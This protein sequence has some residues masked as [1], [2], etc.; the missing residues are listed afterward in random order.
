MSPFLATHAKGKVKLVTQ[1][2]KPIA[3]II[4]EL[5]LDIEVAAIGTSYPIDSSG[6][7]FGFYSSVDTSVSYK[8]VLGLFPQPH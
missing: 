8:S 7:S 6:S 4:P 3:A 1:Q 5:N 2:L